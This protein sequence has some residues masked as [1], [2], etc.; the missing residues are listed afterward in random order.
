MNLRENPHQELLLLH[1]RARYLDDLGRSPVIANAGRYNLLAQLSQ[2]ALFSARIPN[3]LDTCKRCVLIAFLNAL[4]GC[5]N[6]IDNPV[7][8]TTAVAY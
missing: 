2:I 8:L 7:I 4:L 3:S 1:C 5:A 6:A